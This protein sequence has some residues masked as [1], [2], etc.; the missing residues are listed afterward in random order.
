VKRLLKWSLFVVIIVGVSWLSYALWRGHVYARAYAA[1]AQRDSESR[2]LQLFGPPHRVT[3]QPKNVAWDTDGSVRQNGGECI[4]EFWY[5]P[6]LTIV[7]ES[8]TI[9]FDQH[10]NVISKYHY[11]SP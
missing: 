1:V 6:P 7:G 10:S 9:G 4:R 8:W 11:L 5:S 2:V 3:G